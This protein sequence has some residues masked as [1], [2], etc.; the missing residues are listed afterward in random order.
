MAKKVIVIFHGLRGYDSHL[1][2]K[3]I[4]R[5]DVKAY[6]IPNG[7]EKYLAFAIN[8]HLVF[9]DSI[10]FYSKCSVR[11]CM[12]IDVDSFWLLILKA[13]YIRVQKN[14]HSLFSLWS[15]FHN[16]GSKVLTKQFFRNR[17][18]DPSFEPTFYADQEVQ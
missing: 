6:V 14:L 16:G 15:K 4:G 3:E 8:K 7:L 11:S 5:F 12:T 10:Q 1:I 13:L 17:S 18:S 2:I 9:I